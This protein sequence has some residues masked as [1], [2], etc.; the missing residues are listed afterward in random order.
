MGVRSLRKQLRK[1]RKILEQL[2][3]PGVISPQFIL[4]T[5]ASF[6]GT[7]WSFRGSFHRTEASQGQGFKP[8]KV[9]GGSK[10]CKQAVFLT[11]QKS[12]NFLRG[13]HS[14]VPFLDIQVKGDGGL[15]FAAGLCTGPCSPDLL[16]GRPLGKERRDR[17]ARAAT[18]FGAPRCRPKGAL[19]SSL[20][21]SSVFLHT[22]KCPRGREHPWR[23][24]E[25]RSPDRG[26]PSS[27]RS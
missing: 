12:P 6:G 23:H 17:G 9:P 8:E 24:P 20:L 27:S 7:K 4:H 26:C 25:P 19:R 1:P 5:W 21:G 2:L 3:R 18:E 10:Y 14:G 11:G 13:Y 15:C 22:P 16:K